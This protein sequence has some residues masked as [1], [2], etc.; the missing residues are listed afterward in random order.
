MWT[1]FPRDQHGEEKLA[2]EMEVERSQT[3]AENARNPSGIKRR[4]LLRDQAALLATEKP[5][6]NYSLPAKPLAPS[7]NPIPNAPRAPRADNPKIERAAMSPVRLDAPDAPQEQGQGRREINSGMKTESSEAGS[8]VSTPIIHP[9]RSHLFQHSDPPPELPRSQSAPS[10]LPD[11]HPGENSQTLPT[12][13]Q[14]PEETPCVEPPL[15]NPFPD[16]SPSTFTST[17]ASA[18]V[19][20]SIG[21]QELQHQV[22][23]WR[24]QAEFQSKQKAHQKELRGLKDR[25][26]AAL[27]ELLATAE[28]K[29]RIAETRNATALTALGSESQKGLEDCE[30]M[31]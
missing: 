12:P 16:V 2:A 24:E 5:P 17:S 31:I 4:K 30:K 29:V 14:Q 20:T 21:I 9:S 15:P 23:Y 11:L 1:T 10:P 7:P 25:E 18:F 3:L 26:I 19:S 13:P 27:R 8:M 28:E 22:E 6:I